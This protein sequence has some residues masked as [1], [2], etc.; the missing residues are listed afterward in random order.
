MVRAN[1]KKGNSVYLVSQMTFNYEIDIDTT[2]LCLPLTRNENLLW[3]WQVEQCNSVTRVGMTINLH[4]GY[5]AKRLRLSRVRKDGKSLIRSLQGTWDDN[6]LLNSVSRSATSS[7][8][9]KM[10]IQYQLPK[11]A[12]RMPLHYVCNDGKIFPNV[13]NCNLSCTLYIVNNMDTYFLT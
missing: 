8:T 1:K 2:L 13:W 9:S 11:D 10:T 6:E 12:T 7:L 3:G 4:S 5:D